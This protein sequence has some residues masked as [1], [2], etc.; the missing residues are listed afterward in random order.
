[1]LPVVQTSNKV[2]SLLA[3][4]ISAAVFSRTTPSRAKPGSSGREDDLYFSPGGG[5]SVLCKKGEH[6]L[7]H[8]SFRIAS[9]TAFLFLL[10]EHSYGV[11]LKFMSLGGGSGML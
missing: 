1:M 3:G 9:F 11:V 6:S 8:N 4:L 7:R 10:F 5:K 2:G